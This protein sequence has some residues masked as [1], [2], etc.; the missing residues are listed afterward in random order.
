MAPIALNGASTDEI[1]PPN[2][3]GR[4]LFKDRVQHQSKVRPYCPAHPRSFDRR[5]PLRSQW[6]T[7]PRE[8]SIF[9][10]EQKVRKGADSPLRLH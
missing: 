1:Q 2:G 6:G 9:T 4:D 5:S 8:K 3:H 10:D 7:R